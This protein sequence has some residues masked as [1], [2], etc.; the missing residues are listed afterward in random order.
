MT[1]TKA[2]RRKLAGAH[3]ALYLD[4]VNQWVCKEDRTLWPC[5]TALHL[6][7]LQQAD[8]LVNNTKGKRKS[9]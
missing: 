4:V 7:E 9:P 5:K 8:R 1:L 3:R 6:H 2:Q